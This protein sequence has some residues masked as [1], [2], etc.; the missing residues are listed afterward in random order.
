M[1]YTF[2]PFTKQETNLTWW[3]GAFTEDE[4]DILQLL[5]K[6]QKEAATVGGNVTQ[7]ELH[8]IRRS[9]VGWLS[10]DKEYSWVYNKLAHVVNNINADYYQFDLTGFGEPLQLTNYDAGQQGMYTWHQDFGSTGVSRKLSLVLQL[11]YPNEYEGGNLE[12]MN[13]SQASIVSRAR[14]HIAIF[15]SWVLHQVTPVISGSRQSLV[16]WITGPAF[17]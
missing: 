13:G 4:L 1:E 7:A 12:V 8:N 11:S 10:N 6:Q 16:T 15:P 17:R 3:D 9:R 14:G 2:T 5:V